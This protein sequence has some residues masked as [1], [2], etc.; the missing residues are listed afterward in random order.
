MS[1]TDAAGVSEDMIQRL[2]FVNETEDLFLC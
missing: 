1:S 2:S